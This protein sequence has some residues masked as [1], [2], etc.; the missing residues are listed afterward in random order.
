MD[1]TDVAQAV[2]QVYDPS[3][4]AIGLTERLNQAAGLHAAPRTTAAPEYLNDLGVRRSEEPKTFWQAHLEL[5]GWEDNY[6]VADNARRMGGLAP[7]EA[8]ALADATV[9]LVGDYEGPAAALADRHAE[10]LAEASAGAL[11]RYAVL[12][13]ALGD[14]RSFDAFREVM[15][16]GTVR[17]ATTAAHRYAA[18]QLKRL[19]DVDGGIATLDALQAA[20]DQ[21]VADGSVSP[22]DAAAIRALV[23]NLRALAYVQRKEF[24]AAQGLIDHA[25]ALVQ[26]AGDAIVTPDEARRYQAQVSLNNAQLALGAGDLSRANH[27]FAQNVAR[28]RADT[29]DY[30]SE[31]LSAAGLGL[32]RAGSSLP[33]VAAL[34]ESVTLICHE[35]APLRL[36]L[37]R[38]LLGAALA[39]AGKPDLGCRVMQVIRHDPLG[40]WGTGIP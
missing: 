26:G 36:E 13:S 9:L 11:S 20:T 37:T 10:L 25:A 33:A 3:A 40:F 17:Q 23:D 34:E 27:L 6:D 30:L 7:N 15:R 19:G 16:R 31:A 35:A 22:A 18:T 21:R 2:L 14:R 1:I 24:A 38:K 39:R 5:F 8:I 12:L 29:Q 32:L 4:V 28:C